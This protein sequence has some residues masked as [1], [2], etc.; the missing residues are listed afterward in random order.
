MIK[1]LE[2]A[3][4]DISAGLRFR[5]VW[6]ALARESI[7]DQHRR[8]VLGPLW[9]LVN[10]LAFAGT[11]IFIFHA[12]TT[13]PGYAA[14]VAIGLWVWLF[15][16]E[17]VNNS[18]SLFEREESMIKGTALPLSVY[19]M[20]A[21]LQSTIRAAYPAAG[22]ALIVL[23]S[24]TA[25]TPSA[26]WG[27]LGILLILLITPAVVICFAFFG[28][29]FPD[30]QFLVSNLMRVGM[31]VTPVF[32][33]D[34]GSGG[35]RGAFYHYNPFTWFLDIVRAPVLSGEIPWGALG[36]CTGIGAVAWIVAL[37]LLGAFRRQVA[38][39]L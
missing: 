14:Y 20:R 36:L 15:I 29:F 12:G 7:D 21:T 3:I 28:V 2:G 25:L 8:T 34:P 35:V 9:L 39:V 13:T 23:L 17:T 22:C 6:I 5:L 19:V 1:I 11:F 16:M 30:S 18:V 4:A 32:W 26:A 38:L 27:I 37:L 33:S 31:F 24:G 10:Y